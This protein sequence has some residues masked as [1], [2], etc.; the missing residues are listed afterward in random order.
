MT[1][2][3]TDS[4]LTARLNLC[5]KFAKVGMYVFKTAPPFEYTGLPIDDE[6]LRLLEEADRVSDNEF[7]EPRYR[8]DSEKRLVD[9]LEY[10]QRCLVF[11]SNATYDVSDSVVSFGNK[12]VSWAEVTKHNFATTEKR[13]P[14]ANV[15]PRRS[16]A[17]YV[18]SDN[19]VP[20]PRLKMAPPQQTRVQVFC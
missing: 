14:A 9:L 2:D 17:M 3:L 15:K 13:R 7:A 12:N 5:R 18:G 1:G 19:R 11:P 4:L 8:I 16:V 6:R 10:M 20:L